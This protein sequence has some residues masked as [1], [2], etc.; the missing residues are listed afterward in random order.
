MK[1]NLKILV[2]LIGAIA[3]IFGFTSVAAAGPVVDAVASFNV[4]ADGVVVGFTTAIAAGENDAAAVAI[5][6]GNSTSVA[7]LGSAQRIERINYYAPDGKLIG[8]TLQTRPISN[9]YSD[10]SQ[11]AVDYNSTL[12]TENASQ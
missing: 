1:Y 10:Q 11:A 12:E 8:I 9:V 2:G 3:Y 6:N 5:S 4:N 7:A